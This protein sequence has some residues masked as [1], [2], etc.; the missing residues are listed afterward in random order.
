MKYLETFLE[1]SSNTTSS[2]T[3]KKLTSVEDVDNTLKSTEEQKNKIIAQKDAIEKE[4]LNKNILEP[5][6]KNAA[7]KLVDDYKKDI[8]EFD[9]TV[10]QI[11]KLQQT[12]NK[13]NS[14]TNTTKPTIKQAREKNL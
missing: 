5:D 7:K 6:N 2:T 9:K 11:D 4:F 3:I 14:N 10:K 8:T 1:N 12:L 13:N